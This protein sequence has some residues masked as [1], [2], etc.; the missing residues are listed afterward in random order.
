[1]GFL[2][3][4]VALWF[5]PLFWFVRNFG[6]DDEGNLNLLGL[7]VSLPWYALTV[8]VMGS[9]IA[10]AIVTVMAVVFYLPFCVFIFE[11]CP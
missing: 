9:L 10:A 5:L 4:L 8:L 11:S 1:M 2:K 6:S 3:W 7:A